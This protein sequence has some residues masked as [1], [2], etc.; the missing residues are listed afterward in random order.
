V[1]VLSG[2]GGESSHGREERRESLPNRHL[3]HRQSQVQHGPRLLTGRCRLG[4]LATRPDHRGLGR[5]KHRPR[6]PYA[7]LLFGPWLVG[8]RRPGRKL[9][10]RRREP[11]LLQRQLQLFLPDDQ[12]DGLWARAPTTCISGRPALSPSG[13]RRWAPACRWSA[14]A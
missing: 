4:H 3:G 2:S 6:R 9:R 11:E 13:S 7:Y 14:S 5:R 8:H 1:G 10:R 12:A